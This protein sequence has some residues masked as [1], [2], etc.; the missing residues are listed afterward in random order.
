MENYR[1]KV[2]F[3][4]CFLLCCLILLGQKFDTTATADAEYHAGIGPLLFLIP[5]FIA[6]YLSRTK[7]I[8]W[9][10]FAALYAVALCWL[11][12]HYVISDNYSL[13][14]ELFYA[15]SA[16]FWCVFGAMLYVFIRLFRVLKPF[17]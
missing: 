4:S 17:N 9:P 14:Q 7:R 12:Y 5:G 6:S 13:W 3:F 11:I 16:V 2:G 1:N 8:L 15:I 10:L